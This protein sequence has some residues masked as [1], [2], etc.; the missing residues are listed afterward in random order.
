[1]VI[2]PVQGHRVARRSRSLRL[3]QTRRPGTE[4]EVY[5][6]AFGFPAAGGSVQGE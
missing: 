6:E 1:M 2:G 5:S 3:P 4:N